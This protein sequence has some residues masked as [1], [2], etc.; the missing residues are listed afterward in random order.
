MVNCL[1][2]SFFLDLRVGVINEEIAG[3]IE[4]VE[5]RSEPIEEK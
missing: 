5:M 2:L 3:K 1:S 4:N